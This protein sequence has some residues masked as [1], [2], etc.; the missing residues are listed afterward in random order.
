MLMHKHAITTKASRGNQTM[1]WSFSSIY[2]LW[3]S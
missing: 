3:Y 1:S 2:H